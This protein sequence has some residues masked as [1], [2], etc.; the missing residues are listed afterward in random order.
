MKPAYYDEVNPFV[1][2]WLRNP[3]AAGHIAPGDVDERSIED[4]R[5][6]DLAGYG[7]CHFFAG[8]AGWPLALRI[9]RIA[10]APGIWTGSPHARTTA[11]PQPSVGD[12]L[13]SQVHEADWPT[14][15]ST[16]SPRASPRASASRMSLASARG[17]PRSPVVWDSLATECADPNDRLR[18]LV[19]L[20]Y[21]GECGL[22]PTVA[23]RDFRSP[24]A[25]NHPRRSATR[26][27]P[28]PETF[29]SPVPA[30]LARW[31]MGFPPE[32]AQCMPTET[33]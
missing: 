28:L 9:A 30:E 31:M 18:T 20:I 15:G 25:P 2:K 19:R 3:I 13:D 7:Q 12:A 33:P 5:A 6:D 11:S 27:Q 23:A 29:S 14:H 24:G 17:L 1:A 4:V 10:S 16:S 22:L 8:L 32:W 21:A 26:G